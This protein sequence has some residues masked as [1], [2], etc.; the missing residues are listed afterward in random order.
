MVLINVNP[1]GTVSADTSTWVLH[2]P[3]FHTGLSDLY[4]YNYNV[5]NLK[6]VLAAG[7][8]DIKYCRWDR[9]SQA[10]G[11]TNDYADLKSITHCVF[12]NDLQHTATPLYAFDLRLGD[13]TTFENVTFYQNIISM[14][15]GLRLT[16]CFGAKIANNIFNLGVLMRNCK[17]V[18]YFTNHMEQSTTQLVV[19]NSSVDISDNY[20]EKG[21]VPCLVLNGTTSDGYER[22]VV[23]LNNNCFAYY[24]NEDGLTNN[25][26]RYDIMTNGALNIS[27]NKSFRYWVTRASGIR[28]AQYGLM[29][30]NTSQGTVSAFNDYSYFYPIVDKCYPHSVFRLIILLS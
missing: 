20:F 18:K 29:I 24:E 8:F 11:S 30:C 14:A 17:G 26:N 27:I 16:L 25:S 6:G 28:Q 7:G 1:S 15:G 4:F 21:R 3:E 10:V 23:T 13:A 5:I 22:T 19:E 2:H 9:F 12:F